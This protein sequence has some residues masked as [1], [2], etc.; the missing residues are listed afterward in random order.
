MTDQDPAPVVPDD[1]AQAGRVRLAEWL[2]AESS[3]PDNSAT[4][5]DLAE[6]AAYQ[7]EE[8]LVFVPPGYSNLMFLVADHGISSFQPSLQSLDAAMIAARPQS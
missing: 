7:A 2:T 3:D 5:E 6:W 8:Y 4:P 1:V